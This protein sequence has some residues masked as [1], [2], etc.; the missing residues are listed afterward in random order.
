MNESPSAKAQRVL[1]PY[2]ILD[3]PADHMQEIADSENIKV[4]F[5]PIPDEP[6]FGGQLV[7]KGKS[8]GILI[9]TCIP[10]TGKH[11][12]TLAHE[13]GHYFL[14]HE[15]T[16]IMDGQ[17]GFRCTT[18]DIDGGHSQKEGQANQFAA[19]FLMP[20][21]RLRLMMAGSVL[22]Y[23]LIASLARQFRVSKYACSNRLLEFSREPYVIVHSRGHAITNQRFS[24]A[25]RKHI[26]YLT[27]IPTGTAAHEAI[28][29]KKNQ[30]DFTEC[31]PFLWLAK[32]NSS[33]RLYECT[34][35]SFTAGVAMTILKWG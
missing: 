20:E 12:F 23:T 15:P 13:F 7:Y 33:I 8:A 34:H 22:D 14:K 17:R 30:T 28:T 10:S 35:G 16:Y 3:I 9:N 32:A 1:E 29:M 24:P 26:C 2:N 11:N 19:E 25:A 4:L 27:R 5:R 31:D 21:Q 6:K 18:E